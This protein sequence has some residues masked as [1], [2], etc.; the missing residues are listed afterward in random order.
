MKN[1]A[2]LILTTALIFP[3]L[4]W[5]TLSSQTLKSFKMSVSGT[6][7]LHNWESGVSALSVKSDINISE[8]GLEAIN[9][10]TV[11]VDAKSIKSEH[12]A[13]M[14]KKTWESLK[15]TQ[16]P[17]I[18]YQLT[19]VES[20]TP[21]GAGEYDIKAIGNLTIAGVKLP[22]DMNV[23]GKILNGGNL[24]FKGA[25]KVK[26]SDFKMEAPTALMG[27]IKTGNEITVTFDIVLGN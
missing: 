1:K 4:L 23:K 18:T 16:Y 17:K 13:M 21:S 9:S 10:L 6:S 19:K 2:S 24:S 20:I 25:K 27:T 15:A 14:D 12:G 22:I 3:L 5:M 8:G 11:E 7:T 26:M